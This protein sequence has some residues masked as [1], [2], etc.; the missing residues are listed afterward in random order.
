MLRDMMIG[1]RPHISSA[2]AASVPILSGANSFIDKH[3]W[4]TVNFPAIAPGIPLY[5]HM[6]GSVFVPLDQVGF[7][8]H[9]GLNLAK[10]KNSA[11]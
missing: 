2:N 1:E 11:R 4:L 10:P 9:I 7:A 6:R 3:F 8:S 5:R